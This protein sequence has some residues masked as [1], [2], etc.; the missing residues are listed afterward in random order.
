MVKIFYNTN[1]IDRILKLQ[2][3]KKNKLQKIIRSSVL[4]EKFL[5]A[6]CRWTKLTWFFRFYL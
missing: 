5:N 2:L 1:K 6:K 3:N 4:W